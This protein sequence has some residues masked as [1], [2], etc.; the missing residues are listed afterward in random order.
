MIGVDKIGEIRRAYFEQ[1]RPIKEIV[2]R[3]SVSRGTVRKI[4]RGYKTEHRYERD[5][6][7]PLMRPG[8]ANGSRVL[9]GDPGEAKFISPGGNAV[10]RSVCS[11]SCAVAATPAPTTVCT[12]SSRPGATNAPGSRPRRMCR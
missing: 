6:V 10:R 5:E 1:H 8:L 11:R 9:D 12:A 2:R 7:Q 4:V 3:L